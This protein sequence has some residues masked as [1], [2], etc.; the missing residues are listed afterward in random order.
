[1]YDDIAGKIAIVTGGATGIGAACA[2]RLAQ[3]GAKV[4]ITCRDS[5][6]EA[7]RTIAAI[8][9]AGG[10][11]R[12]V[13]CDNRDNAQITRLIPEVHQQEGGLD[14][15]IS[16]AGLFH[17]H[18]LTD[19]SDSAYEETRQVNQDAAFYLSRE[20]AKVMPSGGRI[21]L[22][23]SS[24]GERANAPGTAS[25]AMTKFALAGLARALAHD[26]APQGITANVIQPGPIDTPLNPDDGGELSQMLKA[27]I[28]MGRYGRPEE[29]AALAAFLSSNQ[30]SFI[31]G[32][33]ITI[34]GGF[35]A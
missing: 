30:S 6:D 9:K 10:F 12:A 13:C 21:I 32:S 35:N 29:V 14:I 27:G 16:N 33:Q 7:S 18:Q 11:A 3:E 2:I 4:I 1:M 25:Y 15:L 5:V 28:P 8:T 17:Y 24:V 19:T 26:L 20:A 34:D 23:G 22:I 31:T